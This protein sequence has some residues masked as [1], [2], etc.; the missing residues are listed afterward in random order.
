V[1]RRTSTPPRQAAGNSATATTL[2]PASEGGAGV[3][4]R[5]AEVLQ[6]QHGVSEMDAY[7]I[8]VNEAAAAGTSVREVAHAL[9]N[10]SSSSL[11]DQKLPAPRRN[12]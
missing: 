8:M 3:F 11:S 12:S 1:D 4:Y 10:D 6:A 2:S 5:A 7:E 9:C